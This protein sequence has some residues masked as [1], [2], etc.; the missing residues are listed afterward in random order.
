MIKGR[1]LLSLYSYGCRRLKPYRRHT[2]PLKSWVSPGY[3]LLHKCSIINA[4]SIIVL[5]YSD[6]GSIEYWEY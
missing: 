3:I 1:V 6:T 4:P 5:L 2:K